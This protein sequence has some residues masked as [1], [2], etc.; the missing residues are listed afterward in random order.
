[1]IHIWDAGADNT[2]WESIP[3]ISRIGSTNWYYFDVQT[4]TTNAH[5]KLVTNSDKSWQSDNKEID[6]SKNN[7][8]YFVQHNNITINNFTGY[9][10]AN[11]ARTKI[12]DLSKNGMVL[13]GT[14][15]I[16]VTIS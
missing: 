5:F 8:V 10:I 4:S 11:S 14:L 13:S 3:Y 9:V 1:M 7:V 12:C 6:F 16:C 2:T 15:S